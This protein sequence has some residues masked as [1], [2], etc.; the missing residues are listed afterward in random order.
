[1]NVYAEAAVEMLKS[2]AAFVVFIGG[3]VLICWGFI[4]H[5]PIAFGIL[6]ALGFVGWY[7]SLVDEAEKARAAKPKRVSP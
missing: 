2:I 1:M 6:I 5:T 4:N 3:I 7:F